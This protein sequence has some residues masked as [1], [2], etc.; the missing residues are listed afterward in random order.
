MAY[1][2][3]KSKIEF[4]ESKCFKDLNI[5]TEPEFQDPTNITD[6]LETL[7]YRQICGRLITAVK[8]KDK[9]IVL[10]I[11]NETYIN[12]N[13]TD[14]SGNSPLHYAV[15]Y[16][17]IDI[18][19]KLLWYGKAQNTFINK[20]GETAI[21]AGQVSIES[22]KKNPR[23]IKNN[24]NIE[25]CIELIQ[26]F[27]DGVKIDELK[28]DINVN[29]IRDNLNKIQ[30]ENK[31]AIIKIISSKAKNIIEDY[32]KVSTVFEII[33]NMSK[34]ND[35]FL[36]LYVDVFICILSLDKAYNREQGLVHILLGKT[37]EYYTNAITEPTLKDNQN[38]LKLITHFY[39]KKLMNKSFL[40]KI[41][42]DLFYVIEQSYDSETNIYK[43]QECIRLLQIVLLNI[44]KGSDK[45]TISKYEIK[46]SKFLNPIYN[47]KPRLKFL[48][49]D[50]LDEEY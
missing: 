19:S 10:K 21:Q 31:E 38:I 41:I 36:G 20:Y 22:N 2:A 32:K 5:G 44:K 45:T 30:K 28:G 11:L 9:D 33:F 3:P 7:N 49:Q 24:K 17:Q 18:T 46:L 6:E 4:D 8:K 1:Q 26:T 47:I 40:Q 29:A 48:I 35:M 34:D 16:G 23:Y 37:F 50:Y 15:Y 39:T 14:K 42:D 12:V 25:K 13:F 27:S 43:E